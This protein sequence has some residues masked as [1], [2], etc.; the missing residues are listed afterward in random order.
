M[1]RLKWTTCFDLTR[2]A[3]GK[4]E[5]RWTTFDL[6][7]A[8]ARAYVQTV[9]PLFEWPNSTSRHAVIAYGNRYVCGG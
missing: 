4:I 8:V 7:A 5:L 6:A 1:V 9:T 3:E 2:I